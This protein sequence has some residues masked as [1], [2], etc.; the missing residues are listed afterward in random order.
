MVTVKGER[1]RKSQGGGTGTGSVEVAGSFKE[2]GNDSSSSF[3]KV[4]NKSRK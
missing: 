1:E 2:E 4:V 3:H